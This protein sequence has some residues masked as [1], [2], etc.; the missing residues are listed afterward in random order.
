LRIAPD[1]AAERARR[2]TLLLLDCDG[3]LT[4]GTILLTAE[5]EE[6][7]RFNIL[8]GHGIVLWHR[9]GHRAGVLTGRGSRALER[10]VE[11]LKIEYLIQKSLDK[12]ESFEAFVAEAGVAHDEIAYVGDDVVDVPLLR[13]A[14]FAATPPNAVGE[15]LEAAHAVTERAGGHGAVRE[16]VEFLL[17]AQGRWDE[18]MG[19]YRV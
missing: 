6:I 5:G 14:G 13:R 16:V 1:E 17:K 12:L 2:V 11:E 18:L 3:V 4:D 8:D 9:V 19:R 15:A 10:R 7:K